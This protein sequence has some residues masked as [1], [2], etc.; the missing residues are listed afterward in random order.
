MHQELREQGKLVSL[1]RV[2]RLMKKNAI[3]ARH[4]RKFRATTDARHDLPVAPNLFGQEF[5]AEW[6]NQVLLADVTYLWTDEWWLY[7][8]CVLDLYSR[9]R[10]A[11]LTPQS[12]QS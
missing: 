7:L 10:G 6:P 8:A 2:R 3:A 12:G 5:V 11:V 9:N 1:N 4:R